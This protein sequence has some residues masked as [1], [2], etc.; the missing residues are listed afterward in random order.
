MNPVKGLSISRRFKS[1]DPQFTGSAGGLAS[2]SCKT[3]A[4]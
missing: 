1:V 2:H 3:F 4:A